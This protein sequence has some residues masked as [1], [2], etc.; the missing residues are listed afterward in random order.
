MLGVIL[1]NALLCENAEQES[2]RSQVSALAG[3]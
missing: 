1:D 2:K 3:S